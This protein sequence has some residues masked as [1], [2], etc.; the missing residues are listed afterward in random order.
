MER[1]FII[2]VEDYKIRSSCYTERLLHGHLYA[3]GN[4]GTSESFCPS[5]LRVQVKIVKTPYWIIS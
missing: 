3:I 4:N 2:F 5:A 1:H